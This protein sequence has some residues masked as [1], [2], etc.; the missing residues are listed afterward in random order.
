MAEPAV[1]D[2]ADTPPGSQP[3]DGDDGQQQPVWIADVVCLGTIGSGSGG[4]DMAGTRSLSGW[5]GW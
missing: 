3:P 4:G 2:A 1:G 5:I